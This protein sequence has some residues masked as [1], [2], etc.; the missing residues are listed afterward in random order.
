MRRRDGR[1]RSRSGGRPAGED[2]V[3]PRRGPVLFTT[4]AVPVTGTAGAH[5]ETLFR[6]AQAAGGALR[7]VPM[8]VAA[9]VALGL[10]A[11]GAVWIINTSAALLHRVYARARRSS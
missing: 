4:V 11:L 3:R 2:D 1:P 5:S 7:L 9:L 8:V 6:A 10:L